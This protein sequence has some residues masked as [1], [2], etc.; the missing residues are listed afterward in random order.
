MEIKYN[1]I[2]KSNFVSERRIFKKDEEYPVYKHD[3]Y[4]TLVAENGEFNFTEKGL[5][6]TIT[7]WKGLVVVEPVESQHDTQSD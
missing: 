5:S 2:P 6:E 7:N 4:Y 3:G 1:F